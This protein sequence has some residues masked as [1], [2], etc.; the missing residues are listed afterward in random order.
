MDRPSKITFLDSDGATAFEYRVP[1][2]QSDMVRHHTDINSKI[3]SWYE[4]CS[5]CMTVEE[6]IN[7]GTRTYI[8]VC[9]A[10]LLHRLFINKLSPI[11]R[12]EVNEA[13]FSNGPI[14]P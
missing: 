8:I 14:L 7:T 1:K 3:K 13:G 4:E 5:H 11:A 2:G 9:I 6:L 12:S 10:L